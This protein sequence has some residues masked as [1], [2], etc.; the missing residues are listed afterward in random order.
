M[1]VQKNE[2]VI[3]EKKFCIKRNLQ[4]GIVWEMFAHMYCM[5]EKQPWKSVSKPS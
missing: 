4:D 3:N 2:H 1:K 5:L